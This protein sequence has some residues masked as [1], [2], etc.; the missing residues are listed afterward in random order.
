M[1]L[2]RSSKVELMVHPIISTE[3]DYLMGDQFRAML[4]HLN[5]ATYTLV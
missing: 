5:T 3:S 2:A 4:D 1:E